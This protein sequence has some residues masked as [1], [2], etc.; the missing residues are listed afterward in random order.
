MTAGVDSACTTGAEV[1][2][3][4]WV[5]VLE[6]G[7]GTSFSASSVER[8]FSGGGGIDTSEGGELEASWV[9]V[10][11]GTTCCMGGGGGIL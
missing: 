1:G 5:S 10:S 3:G 9:A 11:R 2:S 8:E 7:E 4:G 6:G